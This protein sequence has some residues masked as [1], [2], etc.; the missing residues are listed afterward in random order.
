MFALGIHYL[1][2][3]SMAAADGAVKEQAEWPPH[4]D[5]VFMALAAAFFETG[6]D[7]E[8]KAALHWL[9][10]LG[11]PA[12]VASDAC[13]RSA[14]ESFVPVNDTML[15]TPKKPTDLSKLNS[16]KEKQKKLVDA[17]LALLP[18]HR[19]LR[20]RGFPVAVP[21]NPTVHLVWPQSLGE[22]G[23]ALR[24]L[25]A[26]VTNIGHSASLVQAWI[27]DGLDL[28]M[29]WEPTDG[30]AKLRLRIPAPNRLTRLAELAKPRQLH[31]VPRTGRR[32]QASGRTS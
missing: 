5:R 12:I 29:S 14:A 8:E 32:N 25:A 11:P 22:H 16:F 27:H 17:G 2:G 1:N 18:D 10:R 15:T 24:I 31:C 19:N 23:N 26:K 28:R 9:E 6:Q 30:V 4:P 13:Q 21:H 3:W 20:G 7:A